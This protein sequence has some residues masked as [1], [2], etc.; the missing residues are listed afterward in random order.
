[1]KSEHIDHLLDQRYQNLTATERQTVHAHIEACEE[2]LGKY[3]AAVVADELIYARANEPIEV[4]PFFATRVMASVRERRATR[5]FSFATL[6]RS[7][8]V[9]LASMISLVMLLVALTFLTG[10]NATPVD[11]SSDEDIYTAEWVIVNDADPT[12]DVTDSQ[13]LT[14][15]YEPAGNNG[16]DK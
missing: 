14:T 16:Q 12:A 5:S 1:M 6:L 7:A 2:C 13:V 8:R 9:P 4:S 11:Q 15:L 10:R 3:R